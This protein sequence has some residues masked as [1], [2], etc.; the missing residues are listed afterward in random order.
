MVVCINLGVV[1]LGKYVVVLSFSM[2][3]IK[4]LEKYVDSIMNFRL[5]YCF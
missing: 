2:F 5:G 1:F 4:D 3:S